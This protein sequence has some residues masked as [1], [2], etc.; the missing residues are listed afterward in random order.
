MKKYEVCSKIGEVLSVAALMCGLFILTVDVDSS[1]QAFPFMVKALLVCVGVGIIGSALYN[2]SEVEGFF[3]S[4]F[5][6]IGAGTY[7]LLRKPFRTFR[8][9]YKI[10]K[11]VDSF[12][13]LREIYDEY[14][15]SSYTQEENKNREENYEQAK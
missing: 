8:R 1:P 12:N 9:C 10:V 4:L 5:I 7:K 6:V 15:E 3:I 2:L 11:H 13:E 14:V